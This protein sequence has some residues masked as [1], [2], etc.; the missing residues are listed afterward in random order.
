VA[1]NNEMK[2]ISALFLAKCLVII[3][4]LAGLSTVIY[5]RAR[6]SPRF[7]GTLA[8]NG[9]SP[10]KITG[11]LKKELYI[12]TLDDS[13]N[14]YFNGTESALVNAV[15]GDLKSLMLSGDVND[16][17][18]LEVNRPFRLQ[19]WRVGDA[20]DLVKNHSYEY[21]AEGLPAL[22]GVSIKLLVKPHSSASMLLS[23]Q[24]DILDQTV[25]NYHQLPFFRELEA[26]GLIVLYLQP[27]Q[28]DFEL[29]DTQDYGFVVARPE[30][31]NVYLDYDEP[32]L[33]NNLHLIDKQLPFIDKQPFDG[34]T[35]S[36]ALFSKIGRTIRDAVLLFIEKL[37]PY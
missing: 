12:C 34:A 35:G 37:S 27:Q 29:S 9:T 6:L 15:Y 23:G 8:L 14:S 25:T 36:A 18:W 24:C 10:I 5:W 20:I 11:P 1:G 26:S 7:A 17:P 22:D 28:G 31:L 3:V 19:E 21:A 30:V 2:K 33:Y 32:S 13:F 4:L 16:Q